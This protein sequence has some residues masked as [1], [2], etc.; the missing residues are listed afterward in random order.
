MLSVVLE[1]FEG[2]IVTLYTSM[3]KS[4]S[5]ASSVIASS[6]CLIHLMNGAKFSNAILVRLLYL[7]MMIL[8]LTRM[9]VSL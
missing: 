6:I 8:T 5:L 4:K 2:Y 9:K 7:V 1:Q 3:T